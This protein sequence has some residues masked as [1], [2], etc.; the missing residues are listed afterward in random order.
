MNPVKA[1]DL[2]NKEKDMQS[3]HSKKSEPQDS[4]S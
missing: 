4:I 3:S 2:N 1:S